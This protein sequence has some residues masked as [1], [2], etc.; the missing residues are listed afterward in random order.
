MFLR[1][2]IFCIKLLKSLTPTVE[3]RLGFERDI[4]TPIFELDSRSIFA[5]FYSKTTWR[6]NGQ[7]G[8]SFNNSPREAWFG[9]QKIADSVGLFIKGTVA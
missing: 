5:I 8:C 4:E 3:V 2:N 6:S 9:I 7:R 1:V